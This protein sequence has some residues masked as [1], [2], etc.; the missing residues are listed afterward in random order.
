MSRSRRPAKQ[1]KNRGRAAAP[2]DFWGSA[3]SVPDTVTPVRP[4]K[5][6]S[7][8]VRSLGAP[9]LAGHEVIAEHY[10]RAVYDRSAGLAVALAAGNG[11]LADAN[12]DD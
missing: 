10:F 2:R 4:A 6:A 12:D 9:P 3:E 7:A 8:L 11:L 5:D 1:T